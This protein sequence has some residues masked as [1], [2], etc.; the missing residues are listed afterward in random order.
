MRGMRMRMEWS[1]RMGRYE[2]D[3]SFGWCGSLEIYP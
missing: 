3:F 1:T 2:D